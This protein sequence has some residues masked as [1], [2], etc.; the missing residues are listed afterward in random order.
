MCND[1]RSAANNLGKHCLAANSC[2]VDLFADAV[3]LTNVQ[4]ITSVVLYPLTY[5]ERSVTTVV[6]MACN[7]CW[8]T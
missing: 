4:A 6:T 2:Q 5:M 8:Q 3:Y 7:R 1:A